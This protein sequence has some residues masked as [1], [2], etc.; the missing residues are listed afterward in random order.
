MC[1]NPGRRS[2]KLR[3]GVGKA[4]KRIVKE[5]SLKRILKFLVCLKNIQAETTKK[6]EPF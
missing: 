1:L 3:V 2:Q 5:E 6:E 4:S